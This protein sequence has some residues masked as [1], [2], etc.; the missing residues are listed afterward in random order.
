MIDEI[1]KIVERM[2]DPLRRR[3]SLMVGRAV[4]SAA[5][6]DST[7]FQTIQLDA[8]ATET[9]SGLERFQNYGFTS[10]PFIGSEAVV[11][12]P[13]GNRDHGL[14][15]AIDDRKYRLKGLAEGEVALYTDEGDNII[16]K[17]GGVIEINGATS[18]TVNTDVATVNA[19]TSTTV[20]TAEATI[21]ASTKAKIDSPAIELGTLAVE[22]V[23][24]GNTFQAL[25]NAHVHLGNLGYPTDE[26][27][28]PLIGDELSLVSK[29][30]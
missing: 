7:Q 26:P 6:D 18:V 3:I 13:Q 10:V 1:R 15:I 4:I 9:L 28:I 14:V 11:V 17:R 29:T 19:T 23:I 20:T 16:I 24:K 30:Q 2:I 27:T 12:F 8:L 25:F 21:N 5:I 22:A